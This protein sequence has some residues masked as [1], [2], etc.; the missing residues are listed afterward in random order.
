MLATLDRRCVYTTLIGRY[1][2]LNE[3]PVARQSAIPFICLTDDPGLTSE[4]W[5]VVRVTPLFEQDPVRS[6][7]M[8]KL[9][10][11][12]HLSGFDCSLYIDNSVAL[13]APPEQIFSTYLSNASFALPTH[14]FRASVRDEFEEVAACRLDDPERI[15]DQLVDYATADPDVLRER[16]YWSAV[17][18]RD[19]RDARVYETSEIWAAHVLRY[20]RRDQLSANRAFRRSGF[21]PHRIEIDNY[22]SWF[23]RWPVTEG[24]RD[25]VRVYHSER[26]AKARAETDRLTREVNLQRDR[27]ADAE[28]E[29]AKLQQETARLTQNLSDR[30]AYLEAILRSRS[31]RL[32]APLRSVRRWLR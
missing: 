26:A 8:L 29:A 5:Q 25:D 24:R 31:W 14:S 13:I 16:P 11:H 1:E 22:A 9:R 12:R 30:T 32:T 27:A 10:P 15:A 20:S 28:R 17:L 18:L 23:H 3:Q 4:T 2:K 19:H 21:E 7:R 6:Q